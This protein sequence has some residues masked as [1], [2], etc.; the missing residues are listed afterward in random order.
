MFE[1]LKI[2][3]KVTLA[4]PISIRK[5]TQIMRNTA[6]RVTA[7]KDTKCQMSCRFIVEGLGR[8]G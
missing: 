2:D 3:H 7:G 5:N 4:G 1:C 6:H 8:A